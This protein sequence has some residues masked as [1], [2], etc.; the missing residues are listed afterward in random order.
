MSEN[1]TARLLGPADVRVLADRLGLRPT[2]KLGQNF[3]HDANTVRRIVKSAGVGADDVV[4]EVGPGLG[5]LTLALLPVAARVHV[6]EIDPVLAELLP[7]TVAERAPGLADRLTVTGADAMRVSAAE[8]A[9]DA[10]GAR[11]ADPTAIVANL[12]YNVAVPVILHLLAELPSLERG[13]V[14]V[15]AEVADRLAAGP[16]SRQYGAPSAKLAWYADARRAGPVPRAVFWP[17]PGVDSGLLAF[18]RHDPPSGADRAATF[19][20]IEAAFAQRRK[21]LRGALAG[22][23]GSPAAAETALRAAGIDPTTRAERLSVTDFAA[24]AAHR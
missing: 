11:P 8:L 13:L 14:M 20:V 5:S 12:P 2:K 18:T 19:A 17:V 1:G 10:G 3:V 7:E 15:Q 22:W 23:A 16:G 21:A 9:A 24:V 6:I 4:L